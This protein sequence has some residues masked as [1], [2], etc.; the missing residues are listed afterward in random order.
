MDDTK[1]EE[2]YGIKAGTPLWV[3]RNGKRFRAV[4][5]DGMGDGSGNEC[6]LLELT[7]ELV[8]ELDPNE[9]SFVSTYENGDGRFSYGFPDCDRLV[10]VSFL[11]VDE[12]G[13]QLESLFFDWET[14]R[15]SIF[16]PATPFTFT[17]RELTESEDR[18]SI[19]EVSTGLTWDR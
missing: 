14:V 19:T 8:A 16:G 10:F 5:F 18:E 4:V 9:W 15:W 12:N 3:E 17:K 2:Y 6:L 1:T 7:Q 13:V 11:A